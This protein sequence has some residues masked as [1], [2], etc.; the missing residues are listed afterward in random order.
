[1]SRILPFKKPTWDYTLWEEVKTQTMLI[2]EEEMEFL[3]L[4]DTI[5]SSRSKFWL[6]GGRDSFID[7][8]NKIID[9]VGIS[10][11]FDIWTEVMK[12]D[13]E[14]ERIIQ[15]IERKLQNKTQYPGGEYLLN[16]GID[17]DFLEIDWGLLGKVIGA[18][19]ANE[20]RRQGWWVFK[21]KDT[22][23]SNRFWLDMK[24]KSLTLGG[25]K[26]VDDD[27][28]KELNQLYIQRGLDV[29]TELSRNAASKL[30]NPI[31]KNS[32]GGES[33]YT[34]NPIAFRNRE[35]RKQRYLEFAEGEEDT[36]EYASFHGKLTFSGIKDAIN[37]LDEF[38]YAD[39]ILKIQGICASHLM[40]TNMVQQK[41]GMHLFT[42]LAFRK[43]S[44]GVEAIPVC[45]IAQ[46]LDTG[47]GLS[48]VL[49]ILKRADLIEWYTV[50]TEYVNN[51]L[52]NIKDM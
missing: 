41:I 17:K 43:M 7:P 5:K 13:S 21:G 4:R 19:I 2:S 9:F 50:E 8:D 38:R 32:T 15:E 46:E 6:K 12:I 36:E 11:K 30:T 40:R 26:S 39:F 23:M 49:E 14:K 18:A 10:K 27:D 24:S 20:G 47:F 44:R 16:L 42:N 51:A 22:I 52:K 33:Y 34:I 31:L 35:R 3:S 37:S 28:W 45:D 29:E 25:I 1:M 48:R